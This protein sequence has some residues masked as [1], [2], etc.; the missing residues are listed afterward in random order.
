VTTT[1]NASLSE[2]SSS[3]TSITSTERLRAHTMWMPRSR[4]QDD[5]A[6]ASTP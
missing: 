4:S 1:A 6:E 2:A 5:M 3:H